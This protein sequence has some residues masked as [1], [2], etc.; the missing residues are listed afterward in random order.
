MTGHE[1]RQQ[2]AAVEDRQAEL[3]R[4][5]DVGHGLLDRRGNNQCRAA[6]RARRAVLRKSWTPR[7]CSCERASS[8]PPWSNERSLLE[9]GRRAALN[10]ASALM[11]L[12]PTPA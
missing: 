3:A 8:R 4:R 1:V 5:D 9:R 2:L 6:R 12:P 10:C 11:P 7:R